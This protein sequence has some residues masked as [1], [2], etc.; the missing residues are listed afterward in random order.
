MTGHSSSRTSRAAQGWRR[1]SR[2]FGGSCCTSIRS[3]RNRGIPSSAGPGGSSRRAL[4]L[5]RRPARPARARLSLPQRPHR[6]GRGLRRATLPRRT[7]VCRGR[8]PA[9]DSCL[10]GSRRV[11]PRSP[12]ADRPHRVWRAREADVA[13]GDAGPSIARRRDRPSPELV[14]RRGGR[15]P[16]LRLASAD[17][18]CRS[19]DRPAHRRPHRR[20][21]LPLLE[22]RVD[23][24]PAGPR[25]AVA[26][27]FPR[28]RDRGVPRWLP[29]V[30]GA[31]SDPT[32][33]AG[34]LAARGLRAMLRI[35]ERP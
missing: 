14:S 10:V 24:R 31:L 9:H 30:P 13:V 1:W 27:R 28:A 2:G 21:R 15:S 5:G 26:I 34:R 20:R 23:E 12:A 29:R 18:V 11:R 35:W 33:R 19:A 4:T 17:P 8:G 25:R 32:E 3:T 7:M 16:A 6:V 22:R